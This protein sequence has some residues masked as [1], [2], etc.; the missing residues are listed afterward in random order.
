MSI[1]VISAKHRQEN[2]PEP[3]SHKARI[4]GECI[5][6]EEDCLL[7]IYYRKKAQDPKQQELS[8]AQDLVISNTPDFTQRILRLATK[9][10]YTSITI[11]LGKTAQSNN[12]I[13]TKHIKAI[14]ALLEQFSNKPSQ[15]EETIIIIYT[16][17]Y[18]IPIPQSYKKAI[19]NPD[20]SRQQKAAINFK[21]GQLLMN[22]I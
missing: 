14:I 10:V 21:I 22:N 9:R 13:D 1:V 5:Y 15:E 4:I 12:K 18:N 19:N 2:E 8:S 7:K 3:S 6:S 11:D 20:Y 17:E 16:T